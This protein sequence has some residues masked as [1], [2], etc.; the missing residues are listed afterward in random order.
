MSLIFFDFYSWHLKNNKKKESNYEY[1]LAKNFIPA[2][3]QQTGPL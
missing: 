1:K 3:N 2:L